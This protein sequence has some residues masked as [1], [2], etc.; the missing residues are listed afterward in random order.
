M[1]RFSRSSDLVSCQKLD[2]AKKSELMT[3]IL[4]L[5]ETLF[6]PTHFYDQKPPKMRQKL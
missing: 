6:V 1:G 3:Q 5:A 2:L 4:G